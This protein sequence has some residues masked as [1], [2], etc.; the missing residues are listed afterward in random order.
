MSEARSV[1]FLRGINLGK[2][3][4]T[5]DELIAVFTGLGLERVDTFLASGNVLFQPPSAGDGPTVDEAIHTSIGEALAES[6]GYE[7]PTTVR[8]GAEVEAM[9]T[10]NPFTEAE[11][12][13]TAGRAQA[14]L[15]FDEPTPAAQAE[16]EAMVPD[17]D[18]LVFGPRVI[19]WLPTGGIMDSPLDLDAIG[20]V[21]GTH[22]VRTAN[23]IRRLVPK[24]SA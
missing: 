1:A 21:L 9:A 2:R 19:H 14:I 20:R 6:L 4:V 18:R 7:V 17:S 16:V 15:L 12:A 13:A 11:L 5:G 24:L 10:A 3:R 23:T 8:S 22:T